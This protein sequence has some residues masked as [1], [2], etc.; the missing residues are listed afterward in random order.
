MSIIRCELNAFG[1]GQPF[2]FKFREE[3]GMLFDQV[4]CFAAVIGDV[5]EFPLAFIEPLVA[6]DEFPSTFSNSAG[7]K[8]IKVKTALR[9][10]VGTGKEW[11]EA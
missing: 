3:I 5:V 1:P 8:V 2:L 4:F 7:T 10:S 6:T 9:K 11:R